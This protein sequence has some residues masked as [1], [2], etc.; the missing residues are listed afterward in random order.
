MK[1]LAILN[2]NIEDL[3]ILI[4]Q[5][6]E[7]DFILSADG[8]T[9]YCLKASLIPDVVIGDL[10]SISED[11]LKK[12]NENQISVEKFPVKKD[13]TDSELAL[14]YLVHKGFNDITIV[15]ATGNRMDHTLANI[16]LLDKLNDKG[17]KGRIIDEN[18]TIYLVDNRLYLDKVE[19]SFIS[20]IPIADSGTTISLKGFEYELN[21]VQIDFG[22]T[23]GISN[24][25]VEDKGYI[26]VHKG[27]CL[28]FVS[29][30]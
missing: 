21:K 23:H 28:L 20:I 10:D 26:E 19:N 7:F 17:I 5:E 14:D 29:K 27:R 18:N 11:T 8:G 22:S 2:G 30:D 15:G 4:K 6:K 13:A 1:A 16:F 24:I 9:D 25:I 12:I 3:G